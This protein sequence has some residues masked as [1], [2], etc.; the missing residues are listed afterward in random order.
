MKVDITELLVVFDE[1]LIPPTNE[2][3][4]VYWF[5]AAR[6]D[7]LKVSLSFSIYECYVDVLIYSPGVTIA[8]INMEKCS[9]IR[10]LDAEKK[11]LEIV[12]D[13]VPGRC[14]LHLTGEDVLSYEE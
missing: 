6:T 5:R 13:G 2:E 12:H 10:V 11:C 4:G 8:S 7:D 3:L 14:F 1:L 9:E